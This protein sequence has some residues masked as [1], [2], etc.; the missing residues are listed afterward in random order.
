MSSVQGGS[1]RVART[2]VGST[3][4]LSRLL[5]VLLI[6]STVAF[7]ASVL[8]RPEGEVLLWAD[9]GLYSA[10]MLIAA[11]LAAFRAIAGGYSMH[12]WLLIAV[13][14]LLYVIGNVAYS[15]H[16][17]LGIPDSVPMLEDLLW[18]SFYPLA[19]V[20]MAL[21]TKRRLPSRTA[22]AWL[23]SLVVGSGVFAVGVA[24][25]S[26]AI[27]P[28]DSLAQEGELVIN[29]LYLVGD[30][31]ILALVAM[32]VQAFNARP[33]LAWWLL[34]AGFVAFAIADGGYL[35]Q[36]A[37]DVYVEG[38]WLDALWPLSG[39]LIGVAA[40][41]DATQAGPEPATRRLSFLEPSIAIVAAACVLAARVEGSMR[42]LSTAA[43]LATIL[44]AVVR[45]NID[46]RE[47]LVL[48][49]RLRRS[50]VDSLTG[51]PNRR[52][53]L[54][55]ARRPGSPVSFVLLDIDSFKDVNETLGHEV[56]D[57]LLRMAAERLSERVAS[58]HVLARM[59]GDEFGVVVWG[60]DAAAASAMAERL[61][62]SLERPL[63]L[64]GLPLLV[65]ACAG[66]ASD[67]GLEP[68]LTVLYRQAEMALYAAK[69]HG[70]GL[71]RRHDGRTGEQTEA[72]LRMRAELRRDLEA[73][74]DRFIMHYQPILS[75]DDRSLL[76]VE[77]LVRWRHGGKVL[78]PGVFLPEV[79]RAG[80]MPDLTRLV[81]RRSL[82]EVGGLPV[83]IPVTVNVPP[84]LMGNWIVSE[85]DAVLAAEHL[86]PNHLVI[87]ITEEAIVR[88]PDE[89]ARILIALRDRGVRS[90]LDDFG[91]GWSGLSSLRDLVV[92]GLKIDGS[93]VSRLA[94]DA[95]AKS[96]VHGVFGLADD[97]ELVVICEGAE[98]QEVLDLLAR[99]D[100]GYVQ[101]FVTARPMPIA[102]LSRWLLMR[103][104]AVRPWPAP[105]ADAE[106]RHAE[107]SRMLLTPDLTPDADTLNQDSRGSS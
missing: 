48:T 96:I 61:L 10:P 83:T 99:F 15:L 67:E 77:A 23:D 94:T 8:F 92:D 52:G 64:D 29:S 59:G 78:A 68:D 90:L 91:T 53:L 25:V 76:A 7:V 49:S 41:L 69:S 75:L 89:V 97:L 54:E 30:L 32:V 81:L 13:G 46:V 36:Q 19:F 39:M 45:L 21:L 38:A 82:R 87:E 105:R 56:G 3:S 88:N 73:G 26:G 104:V 74:G 37:N 60:S 40:W 86:D 57:R 107:R 80:Q 1:A 84:E 55:V 85:V 14:L 4:W 31:V 43:A 6:L 103:H 58:P 79:I 44:L 11:I 9:L 20:G 62:V 28:Q 33:P 65:T 34:L 72:R 16:D 70:P 106:G 42:W 24:L 63:V 18:M 95:T 101:G 47:S 5:V 2:V 50:Q 66:V 102:D 71:V 35:L 27:L 22:Y 98:D 93:F 12:A 100:R 17:A 51:L